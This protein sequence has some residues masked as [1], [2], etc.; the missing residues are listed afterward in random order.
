[1]SKFKIGKVAPTYMGSYET[2]TNYSELDIVEFNG[3]SYIAR[4]SVTG[5]TPGTDD[6]SWGLIANKGT[7][8]DKGE[9]GPKGDRGP[10]GSMGPAGDK[11]DQGPKGDRG[12]KGEGQYSFTAWSSSPDGSTDFTT[13]GRAIPK[14]LLSYPSSLKDYH[15]QSET[16]DVTKYSISQYSVGINQLHITAPKGSGQAVGIFFPLKNY[17]C[18][19]QQWAL[20]F[21]IISKKNPV[22]IS[23]FWN[24]GS[25]LST[26]NGM[27][28][29]PSVNWQRVSSIGRSNNSLKSSNV[30][31]YFDTTENDLDVYI[32]MPKF[33]DGNVAS[34]FSPSNIEAPYYNGNLQFIGFCKTTD[35]QAPTD[36]KLYQWYSA[37]EIFVNANNIEGI[38][39]YVLYQS[40]SGNIFKETID[41]SGNITLTKQ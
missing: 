39:D 3:S 40:P 6:T 2:S 27:V 35:Q 24:E 25:T 29:D 9:Q 1:M 12:P 11:G 23:R 15:G 17:T 5:V 7:K 16:P 4:Q 33:E 20:S 28:V 8:G 13:A 21:D 38:F 26:G 34:R 22:T 32:K 18:F 30:T 10:Q 36:Y 37:P 41:D 19:G 31:I 14:N